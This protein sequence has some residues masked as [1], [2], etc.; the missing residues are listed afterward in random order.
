M[1]G[2]RE[3]YT[4]YVLDDIRIRELFRIFS[5][6]IAAGDYREFFRKY[7]YFGVLLRIFM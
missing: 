5:N 6:A 4:E 7:C 3:R 1:P 2:E